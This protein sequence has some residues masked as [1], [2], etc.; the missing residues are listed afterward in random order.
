MFTCFSCARQNVASV[1]DTF[2]EYCPA[3]TLPIYTLQIIPESR[4]TPY[5]IH[6]WKEE[7]I[8]Y[9]DNNDKDKKTKTKTKGIKYDIPMC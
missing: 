1:M 8:S 7:D 6:H 5:I 9:D 3:S 2:R 4:Q